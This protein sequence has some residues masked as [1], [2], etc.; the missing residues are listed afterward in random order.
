MREKSLFS[1]KPE[2]Y[3]FSA[4]TKSAAGIGVSQTTLATL[5]ALCVFFS[6]V[7]SVH[8]FFAQRSTYRCCYQIMVAQVGASHEAPVSNVAGYA[9]PAW[10]TTN[11]IGVS[12]GSCT[13][14]T[15]E[16]ALMATILISS[17]PEFTFIFAAIRRADSASRP[18]M[19]RTVADDEHAARRVFARDYVLAFAGRLSHQ[20]V[21]A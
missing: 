6:V 7:A 12:S 8:P 19:L 14:L 18:C 16:A 3:S 9:N 10:A 4:A 15:L 21:V 13:Q 5:D 2:R 11:E 1:G 20:V 17:R